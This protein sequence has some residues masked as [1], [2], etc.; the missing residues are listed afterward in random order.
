MV[1]KTRLPP[2]VEVP[3]PLWTSRLEVEP[4]KRILRLAPVFSVKLPTVRVP[5][6]AES[7]PG[8]SDPPL[9]TVTLPAALPVPRRVELVATVMV[10]VPLLVPLSARAPLLTSVVPA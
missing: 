6:V 1:E 4:P 2:R 9:F 3:V 5:I 8:A 7:A 10:P